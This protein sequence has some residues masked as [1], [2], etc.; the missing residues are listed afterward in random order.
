MI[1]TCFNLIWNTL[2]MEMWKRKSN[3]LSY[4]WGLTDEID[5]KPRPQFKGKPGVNPVT[6]K[7]ELI[8]SK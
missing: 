7:P 4:E 1:F 5:E 8:Y 2:F 3:D 6:N